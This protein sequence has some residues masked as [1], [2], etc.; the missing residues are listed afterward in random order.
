MNNNILNLINSITQTYKLNP[1]EAQGLIT[2]YQ[3]DTRDIATIEKELKTYASYYQHKNIQD[4]IIM[5]TPPLTNGNNYYVM[6]F[7]NN[8]HITLEG[9]TLNEINSETSEIIVNN[10]FKGTKKQTGVDDLEIAICQIGKLLGFDVVEEYRIYNSNKQKDSIIIKDLKNND[11]F[12]DV[13]NLKKR[14]QKLINSGK[15]KKEKW[16][17][18]YQNLTVANTKD[19]YKAAIEYGLNILKILP[20]ILEED[21][22]SIENKYFEMILFDSIIN[23]SER[24][25]EDYGIICNKDTKRY[26]FAPLFDNVFPSILKN[27]DV[28]HFNGITCN[29]YE[30]MESLFHNY[31][32]KIKIKVEYI[33]SNKDKILQNI[34]IIAKYNLDLNTYIMLINNITTNINYIE[35]LSK[36]RTLSQKNENAGFADIA[37]M[38]VILAIIAIFSIA[39]AYLLYYIK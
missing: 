10:N 19:D 29:R 15:I 22:K 36:E 21:Y 7:D 6:T 16:V 26:T 20:S 17:D 38:G 28:F 31:Y 11:E 27:N 14:F 2:K 35:K 9:V 39:I 18:T 13:E 34:D 37:T 25:F 5:H 12:Y 3:N 33:L 8:S 24:K 1:S 32:D 23:Q 4:S 30:L